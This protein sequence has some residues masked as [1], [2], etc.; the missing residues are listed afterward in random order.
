MANEPRQANAPNAGL[1]LLDDQPLGQPGACPAESENLVE[2]RGF[3]PLTFS[4][5]S[6]QG[7][8]SRARQNPKTWW[9]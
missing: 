4:L 8:T 6:A 3:E 9:S 7:A 2:L 5:P 1:Q